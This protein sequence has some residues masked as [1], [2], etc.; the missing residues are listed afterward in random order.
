MAAKKLF[1]KAFKY[2]VADST[3]SDPYFLQYMDHAFGQARFV[4]N[5]LK[6]YIDA[7]LK[8]GEFLPSR[9]D[10]N[11]YVNRHLKKQHPWL[12]GVVDKF[13]HTH[14]VYEIHAAYEAY[15]KGE[16]GEPKFRCKYDQVQT[17][18]TNFT[19]NNIKFDYD[20]GIVSLPYL[21][22]E[23][24]LK[25]ILHRDLE[26]PILG[27]QITRHA[28]GDFYVIILCEY[29]G[30][31]LPSSDKKVGLDLGLKDWVI[32]SD[33]KVYPALKAIYKMEK[34]I[35]RQQRSLSRKYEVAKAKCPEG[36]KV[37]VSKN[38]IKLK[39]SLARNY[40]HLRNMRNDV[41]DKISFEIISNNQVIIAEDLNVQGM[42]KNHKLAKSVADAIFRKL[43]TKLEY[44]AA[45]YGRTF[46][47][48]DRFFPSTQLCPHCGYQNT[49]LKGLKGLSIREWECPNCHA[50]NDRDLSAAIN[51][52]NEGLRLLQQEDGDL[53]L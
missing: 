12:K 42:L 33:G 14:T 3:A 22:K 25:A 52:L 4:W 1:M 19:N 17:V 11:N 27:A 9:I 46:K 20:Q 39:K 45:W 34:R 40:E 48:I 26:G 29:E 51:I 35:K 50:R 16:R 5:Q 2:Q 21:N 28:T 31:E 43:V 41:A 47:K 36:E 24:S 13:Y 30:K 7:Q 37:Q 6:E 49:E 15:L 10:L 53:T 18:T 23:H 44:K 8:L 32:C 38:Y